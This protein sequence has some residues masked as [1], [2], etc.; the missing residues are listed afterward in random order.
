M[1]QNIGI[2]GMGVMGRNLAFNIESHGYIVSIFNRSKEKTKEIIVKNPDKKII[3]FF[4]IKDFIFSLEKP[5]LIFIMVPAG[6]NVDQIINCCIPFL[7]RGDILIDGGNSFYKDTIRRYSELLKKDIQFIG[8]GISGG[9]EGALRGP[10]L[11]PSGSREVY[12]KVEPLF[13]K[14]AASINNEPCVSYIGPDGSGHYVKMVHNG[15]EYSDMQLIAE[16]YSLL[17]LILNLSNDQL[18]N[19]FSEWNSGELNS[20][21]IQITQCIFTRKIDNN[22]YL[23]DLILDEATHKETGKWSSQS[24]LDLGEPLSVITESVFA[25]YLSLLKQQRIVASRELSG[26]VIDVFVGDK[27]EFIENIRRALYLGKII[28]YT[29]GFAQLQTAS[30]VNKWNLNCSEIA[31]VFR[32]GCIIRANILQRIIDAYTDNLALSNLLLSPYFKE[33][34]SSYH[35]SL[36]NVVSYAVINGISVPAFSSAIAYYDA[37]RTAF[38][39]VNLIQAQR[40]Y[41]GAHGYKRVDKE[42]IFYTN[43]IV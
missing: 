12:K 10:S 38:L 28:S 34:A 22:V 21:L 37:Y 15:I 9:S 19:I 43:W 41:F 35:Q 17:K 40:D 2:I 8:T 25:R 7:S 4:S 29:Q 36:R 26:P 3:G 33:I 6:S 16:A 11:M 5:R 27:N 30:I 23:I 1:H 18:A 42:G 20:Y 13:K 39:P 31:K 32:A 24:A 14:I